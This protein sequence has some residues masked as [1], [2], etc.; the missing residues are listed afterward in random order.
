MDGLKSKK[1]I[2]DYQYVV[3]YFENPEFCQRGKEAMEIILI[4]WPQITAEGFKKKI[5]KERQDFITFLDSLESIQICDIKI[6][7][8]EKLE[9]LL[10]FDSPTLKYNTRDILIE[11]QIDE[12]KISK[13]NNNI[14]SRIPSGKLIDFLHQRFPTLEL[15]T[16]F[17][18]LKEHHLN[19]TALEL[20]RIAICVTQPERKIYS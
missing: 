13:I 19:K 9:Y 14:D 2:P 1:E 17:Q 8:K 20:C 6:K 16:I 10:G 5:P 18:I 7:E 11:F 15:K 12:K 3:K 4:E